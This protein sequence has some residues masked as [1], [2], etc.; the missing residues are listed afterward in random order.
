M[1]WHLSVKRAGWEISR[2]NNS[3]LLSFI[4][5]YM[6]R[7]RL[8]ERQAVR[9][10]QMFAWFRVCICSICMYFSIRCGGVAAPEPHNSAPIANWVCF[11][12]QLYI[13]TLP[14]CV[15]MSN[16]PC[17][18]LTPVQQSWRHN[19]T[20]HKIIVKWQQLL[21]LLLPLS[22]SHLFQHWFQLRFH[23]DCR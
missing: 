2:S 3:A 16:S 8:N 21:Q 12:T 23:R 1:P 15:L 11:Q 19:I 7:G 14:Q 9:I 4:E 13:K 22:R 5:Q 6:W 18:T 17:R 20:K 10:K